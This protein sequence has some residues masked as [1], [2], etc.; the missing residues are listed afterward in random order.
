MFSAKVEPKIQ[1]RLSESEAIKIAC[2][3][4][5]ASDHKELMTLATLVERDGKIVWVVNSATIGNMIEVLI[6]D[7]TGNVIKAGRVGK[8]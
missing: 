6:D 4:E 8:R 3:T 1:T 2:E 5:T 7:E